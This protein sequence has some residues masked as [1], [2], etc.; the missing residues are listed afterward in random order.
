MEEMP[1]LIDLAHIVRDRDD[2]ELV[3]ISVDDDWPAAHAAVPRDSGL[4]VLLDPE[5]S[6]VTELFRTPRCHPAE[7][8]A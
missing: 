7:P 8:R 4:T 1:S 5:R 6:V 3:T 2:V